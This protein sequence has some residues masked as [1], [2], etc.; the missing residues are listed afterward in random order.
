M[1]KC[2]LYVHFVLFFPSGKCNRQHL[3]NEAFPQNMSMYEVFPH[4]ITKKALEYHENSHESA[5]CLKAGL[6]SIG[7]N[8]ISGHS[9]KKRKK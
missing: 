6:G 3:S 8:K 1:I 4:N 7:L 5:T 2:L 9:M